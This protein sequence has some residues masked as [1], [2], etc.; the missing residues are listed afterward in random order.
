VLHGD[1]AAH[2][3]PAYKTLG[4]EHRT[5][6][7]GGGITP[8]IFIG[9]DTSTLS[10]STMN[11]YVDGTINRFVY[12]YYIQHL[13]AFRDFKGPG[14]FITGFHGEGEIWKALGH[15]VAKDSVNLASIPEKEKEVLQQRLKALLARQIWRTEGYYEVANASDPVVARA[16]EVVDK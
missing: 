14:D 7:G 9:F 11:L 8:D 10:R 15:Y 12:A 4:P 16:L 13:P 5:V 2:A 1:T 3:G 6:Y